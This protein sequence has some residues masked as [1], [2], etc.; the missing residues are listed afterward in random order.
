M[1]VAAPYAFHVHAKDFLFKP[2]NQIDP[3]D[4]WFKSR[5]GHYL[6]GTIVGHGVVP[7]AQCAAMLK[8]A[9]Y[10]GFLSLE[11]EGMEDNLTALKAGYAYLRRVTD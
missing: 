11:F 8:K 4:G 10:D 1:A 7:V 6:R 2:G 3:G 5:G 9:G